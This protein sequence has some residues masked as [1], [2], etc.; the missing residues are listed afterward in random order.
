[1][2]DRNDS[3]LTDSHFMLSEHAS[4]MIDH[5]LSNCVKGNQTTRFDIS[6][7]SEWYNPLLDDIDKTRS[8]TSVTSKKN[9][10]EKKTFTI[11][12]RFDGIDFGKAD[13]ILKNNV[14]EFAQKGTRNGYRLDVD[15]SK[16]SNFIEFEC[17]RDK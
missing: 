5:A 7:H 14:V 15:V 16:A 12:T 11:K 1:M 6:R 4:K 13:E 10:L 9:N 3:N 17:M 8:I 2:A